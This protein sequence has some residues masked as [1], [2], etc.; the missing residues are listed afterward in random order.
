MILVR[1]VYEEISK[2]DTC[3]TFK[4]TDFELFGD[5]PGSSYGPKEID[6]TI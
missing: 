4:G 3:K 5:F 1:S 6:V 2:E